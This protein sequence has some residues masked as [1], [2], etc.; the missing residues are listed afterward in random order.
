MEWP[1]NKTELAIIEQADLLTLRSIREVIQADYQQKLFSLHPDEWIQEVN[2]VYDQLMKRTVRLAEQALMSQGMGP[3]PVSYVFIVFGSAGRQEQTLWSDQDNGLMYEDPVEGMDSSKGTMIREYFDH[4]AKTIK[5]YLIELGFPPCDGEVVASNPLWCKPLMEW[6]LS[7]DQ[8]FDEANWEHV[9]YLLIAAD[10][11]TLYGDERLL[12]E[13]KNYFQHC[14]NKTPEIV[15]HMLMNTLKHKV[16]LGVFGHFLKEQY[17]AYAGGID[18]KYGAYIPFVNSIRLLSV[19]YEA[20]SAS[21]TLK[22]LEQLEQ[23]LC[24]GKSDMERIHEAFSH[25]LQI[26]AMV[27]YHI[28]D[29]CFV[30]SGV[31]KVVDLTEAQ[32]YQLKQALRTGKWLQKQVKIKVGEFLKRRG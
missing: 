6:K 24:F 11:R 21:S 27:P 29:Q 12:T 28:E 13:W 26:R 18:V 23:M 19:L 25:I 17:G 3:P 32:L 2:D 31:V 10:A 30:A 1:L 7:M 4:L 9:R 20:D 15:S 16:V 8:W 5:L 14:V 22:R